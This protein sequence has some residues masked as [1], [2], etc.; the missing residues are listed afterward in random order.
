MFGF[1]AMS[2]QW[3]P[4]ELW[5]LRHPGMNL[6]SQNIKNHD[7]ALMKLKSYWIVPKKRED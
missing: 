1:R 7:V 3:D 4:F 5:V 6:N 2:E